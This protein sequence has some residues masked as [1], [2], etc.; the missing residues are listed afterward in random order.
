M[1]KER[2]EKENRNGNG[3]KGGV[4]R[5]MQSKVEELEESLSL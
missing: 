2:L 4:L 1:I 5:W 3:K